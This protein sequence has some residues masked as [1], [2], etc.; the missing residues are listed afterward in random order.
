MALDARQ[1]LAEFLERHFGREVAHPRL[2]PIEVVE[3]VTR[4]YENAFYF[5][6]GTVR[7]LQTGNVADGLMSGG[8]VVPKDGAPVHWAPTFPP[9]ADYLDNVA[10][11][12]TWWQTAGAEPVTEVRYFGI[13]G[14]SA[15]GARLIGVMRR[16]IAAS[17]TVDEAFTRSLVWAPTEYFELYRLGHNDEDHIEISGSDA[18]EFVRKIRSQ[19]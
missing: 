19:E 1:R 11:G 8:V 2:G 9:V 13:L 10:S 16:R 12:A 3:D 4:E 15:A 17:K 7:S 14:S 6:V 18:A 5:A